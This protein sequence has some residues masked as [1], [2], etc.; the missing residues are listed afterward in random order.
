MA[1]KELTKRF[2]WDSND[3]IFG[4]AKIIKKKKEKG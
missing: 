2:N 4:E 1:K 3:I